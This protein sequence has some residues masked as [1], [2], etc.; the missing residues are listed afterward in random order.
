M[1]TPKARGAWGRRQEYT[2]AELEA[3]CT[4][5]FG[6][7]VVP[8]EWKKLK[9]Y[10]RVRDGDAVISV[11]AVYLDTRTKGF[12]ITHYRI[13]LNIYSLMGGIVQKK[14]DGRQKVV[15]RKIC[16]LSNK[17]VEALNEFIA[18]EYHRL[19]RDHKYWKL[20]RTIWR[21]RLTTN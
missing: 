20:P 2:E 19:D 11:G 21:K 14:T 13:F 1:N 8:P 18:S 6:R 9:G 10:D 17:T 4:K 7:L 3:E 15:D 5:F 12:G 16:V